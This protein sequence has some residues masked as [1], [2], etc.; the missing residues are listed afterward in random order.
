MASV[1]CVVERPFQISYCAWVKVVVKPG[2]RVAGRTGGDRKIPGFRDHVLPMGIHMSAGRM[3]AVEGGGVGVGPPSLFRGGG[4]LPGRL[5]GR[6]GRPH[7]VCGYGHRPMG[8]LRRDHRSDR[9]PCRKRGTVDAK[10]MLQGG[11]GS[12]RRPSQ[13]EVGP[14]TN[15]VPAPG[16]PDAIQGRSDLPD[17]SSF[18]G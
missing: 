3:S 1:A 18:E 6:H 8:R 7:C 14:P 9:G 17:G 2:F 4:Q 10:A 5:R 12:S 15:Q 16:G 13:R 11:T